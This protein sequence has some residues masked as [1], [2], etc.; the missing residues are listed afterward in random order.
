MK[1]KSAWVC[2]A[3]RHPDSATSAY[4]ILSY[5]YYH[6]NESVV[7]DTDYDD[8][9]RYLL[10]NYN[11]ITHPHKRY[12]TENDLESGTGFAIKDADYPTIVKV[13]A[14]QLVKG[15]YDE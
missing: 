9:C 10:K 4:M 6:L 14:N 8:L 7:S 11:K 2:A 12:F 5:T 15:Y 3:M 13:V 1:N